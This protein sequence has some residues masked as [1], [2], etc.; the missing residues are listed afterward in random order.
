MVNWPRLCEYQGSEHR[1]VVVSQCT[2]THEDGL[3]SSPG[4]SWLLVVPFVDEFQNL[5]F[6]ILIKA[7]NLKTT[8]FYNVLQPFH[9]D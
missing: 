4:D 6:F 5:N 1:F 8:E 7:N 9:I 2:R 3:D